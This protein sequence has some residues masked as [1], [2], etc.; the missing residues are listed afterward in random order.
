MSP[1]QGPWTLSS[2]FG[3]V[4][5]VLGLALSLRDPICFDGVAECHR[6]SVSDHIHF[7]FQIGQF[8]VI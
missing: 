5:R 2:I 4:T 6:G 1:E 7:D 3:S 8:Q